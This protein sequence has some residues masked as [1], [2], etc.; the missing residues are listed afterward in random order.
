MNKRYYTR[1]FSTTVLFVI[2]ILN[3]FFNE[4]IT[5]G[6]GAGWDGTYYDTICKDFSIE[7]TKSIDSYTFQRILPFVLVHY[8][9]DVL[10]IESNTL[11]HLSVMIL[12]NL[13][14]I[15]I[16]VYFF[17]K[18]SDILSFSVS[19]ELIAFSSLFYNYPILK[20][21]GYY[22]LLTDYFAFSFGIM[23]FYFFICRKTT[24]LLLLSLLG[25]LVWPTILLQG[26]LLAFMPSKPIETSKVK[27]SRR[28]VFEYILLSIP[29]MIYLV[30]TI[31]H[32]FVGKFK[33]NLYNEVTNYNLVLL[34]I[35]CIVMYYFFVIKQFAGNGLNILKQFFK[36]VRI[37]NIVNFALAFVFVRLIIY[38]FSNHL[39]RH[40]FSAFFFEMISES[41]QAPL[42][43]LI[44]H[45]A[46]YGLTFLLILFYWRPFWTFV[47]NAGFGYL[48]VV[49][50]SLFLA[51]GN[52]SR[53]L[54]NM[55][56][57]IFI[58][59]FSTLNKYDIKFYKSIIWVGLSLLL[60]RFWFLI[61]VK[62]ELVWERYMLSQGPWQ[63]FLYYVLFLVFF[64]ISF[65]IIK[66][67]RIDYNEK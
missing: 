22:P 11:N 61:N 17:Y 5:I 42:S 13:F 9:C 53:Y 23:L 21:L 39:S 2:L 49:F 7:N 8:S 47:F 60:S 38:Y 52:E 10:G 66:I 28:M 40:S 27:N 37:S 55:L 45:F 46:Y 19:I 16:G 12:L 43:N 57:F 50:L 4:R 3:S 35:F 26:L 33:H 20:L 24:W 56:P 15:L 41:I 65:I 59:V 58:P 34:S 63:P 44:N 14:M 1:F 30:I 67:L 48:F 36:D 54:I 64:I 6:N 29:V 18:I 62:N 25:S 32:V 51:L 31:S